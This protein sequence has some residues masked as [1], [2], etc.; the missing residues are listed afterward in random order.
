LRVLR[1]VYGIVAVVLTVSI[2][3]NVYFAWTTYNVN[4]RIVDERTCLLER[5]KL[6][7]GT[8]CEDAEKAFKALTDEEYNWTLW[9]MGNLHS[10]LPVR[11]FNQS[12]GFYCF[13][14]L[15]NS[16]GDNPDCLISGCMGTITIYVFVGVF[17]FNLTWLPFLPTISKPALDRALTTWRSDRGGSFCMCFDAHRC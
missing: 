17:F 5:V 7:L 8:A 16:S 10:H 13:R 6:M 11:S 12:F 15:R 1:K 9:H 3:L 4:R 2:L 14:S